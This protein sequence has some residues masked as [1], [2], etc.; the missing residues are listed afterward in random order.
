MYSFFSNLESPPLKITITPNRY[1]VKIFT[2]LLLEK[3]IRYST[4]FSNI[5]HRTCI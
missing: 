1:P 4:C 5:L 2:L 3:L